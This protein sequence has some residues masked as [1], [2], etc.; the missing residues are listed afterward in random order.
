MSEHINDMID[1]T[2][3]IERKFVAFHGCPTANTDIMHYVMEFLGYK[4]INFSDPIKHLAKMVGFSNKEVYG[5]FNSREQI[6]EQFG[7]SSNEFINNF[8]PIVLREKSYELTSAFNTHSMLCHAVDKRLEHFLRN[9]YLVCVGDA[10]FADEIDIIDK[11][12]GFKIFLYDND[13]NDHHELQDRF[14]SEI[15]EQFNKSDYYICVAAPPCS[16]IKPL[17]EILA[18]NGFMFDLYNEHMRFTHKHITKSIIDRIIQYINMRKDCDYKIVSSDSESESESYYENTSDYS[19]D[20]DDS[21]TEEG[22]E[23]SESYTEEDNDYDADSDDTHIKK[24]N[25]LLN[26]IHKSLINTDGYFKLMAVLFIYY[27]YLFL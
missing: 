7:I 4:I 5:D 17:L 24:Q 19:D 16:I 11:H 10:R 20:S 6:N 18:E 13:N 22:S 15:Y 8:E 26:T 9:D 1:F 27:M 21:Y 3:N 23:S 2:S 12:N 25:P 14:H